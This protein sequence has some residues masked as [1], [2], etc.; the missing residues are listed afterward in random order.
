MCC[1]DFVRSFGHHA[2]ARGATLAATHR[3]RPSQEWPSNPGHIGTRSRLRVSGANKTPPERGFQERMMGLE[4]TTFC[5]ATRS[6]GVGV[7]RNGLE[8]G[9]FFRR[10]V[11]RSGCSGTR[12]G[13]RFPIHPGA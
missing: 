6:E 8:P 7:R 1:G 12:F 2:D 4:P 10:G 9:L 5:M 11:V 13:T 3:A